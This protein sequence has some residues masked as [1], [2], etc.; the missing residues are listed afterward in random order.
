MEATAAAE[1]AEA[2]KRASAASA[3]VAAVR[4]KAARDATGASVSAVELERQ[5]EATR[6]GLQNER[7]R[8]AKMLV[9]CCSNW[10]S[11]VFTLRWR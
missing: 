10:Y 1:K 4:E 7:E 6:Q 5:E 8:R 11:F 9:R 3:D 2:W